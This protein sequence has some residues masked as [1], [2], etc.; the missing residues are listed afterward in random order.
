M[1]FLRDFLVVGGRIGLGSVMDVFQVGTNWSFG[2]F[3]LLLKKEGLGFRHWLAK[4]TT[5]LQ[6]PCPQSLRSEPDAPFN[7]KP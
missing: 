7:P 3:M 2:R 5:A 4:R 1:Y 6:R